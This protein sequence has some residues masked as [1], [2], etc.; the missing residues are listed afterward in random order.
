MERFAFFFFKIFAVKGVVTFIVKS[1]SASVFKRASFVRSA[2]L[3]ERVKL[4]C[5]I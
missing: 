2:S 3:G 1:H 5:Y 4:F